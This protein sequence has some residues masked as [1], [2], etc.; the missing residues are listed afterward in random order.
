MSDLF[1]GRKVIVTGATRGIGKSIAMAFLKEGATLIGTYHSNHQAAEDF[2]KEAGDLADNCDLYSFDVASYK[3]VENFYQECEQKHSAIDILI[4]NSGIRKDSVLAMM[5]EDDWQQVIQTNLS[6]C[7][8][9]SK[10]AVMNMMRQR[11]GR[12]INISSPMSRLGFSGQANYSASKAGQEGLT[13]SL[14]KEVA[15]RGITVNCVSP[16]F[17]E[18]EL[19][20]DLD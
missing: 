20:K 13:K 17:I 4:N 3:D 10:F 15:S 19:L 8:N 5:S 9:M 12:I 16:G 7:Y 14:C 18:T 2:K 6:G 11:Y 1:A